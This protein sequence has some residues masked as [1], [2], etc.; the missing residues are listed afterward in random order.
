MNLNSLVDYFIKEFKAC[1]PTIDTKVEYESADDTFLISHN[2]EDW[3]N[4]EFRDRK[5]YLMEKYFFSADIFNVC[6]AYSTKLDDI[7]QGH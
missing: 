4:T 3:G 1:Y 6:F 2:C 5:N 7:V